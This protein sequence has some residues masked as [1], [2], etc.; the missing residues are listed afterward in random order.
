V[1]A[2][3]GVSTVEEIRALASSGAVAGAVIGMA[4]YERRLS[5]G[6]ALAAAEAASAAEG[7]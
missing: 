5:L 6:D 3:G 2:S 1:I 7:N 4:L